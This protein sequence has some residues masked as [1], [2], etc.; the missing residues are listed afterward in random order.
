MALTKP[1]SCSRIQS[2]A[3][4]I[5]TSKFKQLELKHNRK[6]ESTMITGITHT[7]RYVPDY[8]QALAFYRDLLGMK[9]VTDNSMAPGKMRWL[10]VGASQQTGVEL[11]LQVPAD[12]MSGEALERAEAQFGKQS[13]ICLSTNDIDAV[14]E[15]LK[16]AGATMRQPE[17]G[18]M[19]WGRDL[20]FSD[21]FGNE[22]Y[23]VEPATMPA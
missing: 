22:I 21:P 17:I 6:V 11:V 12:W 1:E 3:Q 4:A 15:K 9:I 13:M 7:V 5:Q 8:D 23:L 19:P 14:L 2:E 20:N 16:A 18:E 10:G